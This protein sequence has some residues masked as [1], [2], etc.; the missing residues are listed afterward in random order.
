VLPFLALSADAFLPEFCDVAGDAEANKAVRQQKILEAIQRRA[1][2]VHGGSLERND[3]VAALGVEGAE[4]KRTGPAWRA[5]P[6]AKK[7]P[8]WL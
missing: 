8:S 1:Q 5:G 7:K 4:P 3:S 2:R 6:G